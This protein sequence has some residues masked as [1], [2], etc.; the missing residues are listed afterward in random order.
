MTTESKKIQTIDNVE[1][2][3]AWDALWEFAN[4]EI[5][6]EHRIDRNSFIEIGKELFEI[7]IKNS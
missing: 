5:D 6:S 3:K 4:N 7:K 1:L 2:Q